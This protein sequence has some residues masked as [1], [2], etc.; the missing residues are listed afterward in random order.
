MEKVNA[1]ADKIKTLTDNN[2]NIKKSASNLIVNFLRQAIRD[3]Y[4]H[5]DSS[6]QF[7]FK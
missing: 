3:G 1:H 7:I 4:F 6:R 2:F 5:L